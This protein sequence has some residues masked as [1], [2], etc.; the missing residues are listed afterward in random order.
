[1]PDGHGLSILTH[2]QDG[3]IVDMLAEHLLEQQMAD[4]GWNSDLSSVGQER[5]RA[6]RR[7]PKHA[8]IVTTMA[9]LEGL[10]VFEVA[11]GHSTAEAQARGRE[12]LLEHRL[13]RS[14]RTGEVIDPSF[15]RLTFPAWGY[16]V[17]LLDYFQEVDAPCDG[18]LSEAVELVAATRLPDGRWPLL[19]RWEG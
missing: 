11:R 2:V 8:S 13:S 3:D 5:E 6:R 14:H 4:G 17:H 7:P 12:F 19:S 10:R 15:V 18:R 9:A 16:D 1:M